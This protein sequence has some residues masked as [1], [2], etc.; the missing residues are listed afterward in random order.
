MR[1]LLAIDVSLECTPEDRLYRAAVS[2]FVPYSDI[3]QYII[4]AR[5]YDNSYASSTV[6]GN[7]VQQNSPPCYYLMRVNESDASLVKGTLDGK[8]GCFDVLMG[9]YYH[10]IFGYVLGQ[11]KDPWVT[12]DI[13]QEIFLSAWGSLKRCKHPERFCAWLFGIARNQIKLWFRKKPISYIPLEML[14]KEPL[15]EETQDAELHEKRL[16]ALQRALAGLPVDV[17]EVLL[18]KHERGMKSEEIAAALGR[19]ATTI[20]SQLARAYARLKKE[21]LVDKELDYDL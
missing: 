1:I 18:M 8:K 9:R 3:K 5:I 2:I 14:E 13:V 16:V 15:T 7:R 10:R 17:R 12:Q 6:Q 21:L 11:L 20:R 19:P 4:P